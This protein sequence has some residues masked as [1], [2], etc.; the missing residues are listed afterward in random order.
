MAE[1]ATHERFRVQVLGRFRAPAACRVCGGAQFVETD[2]ACPGCNGTG[3][4]PG[5][6]IDYAKVGF[7]QGPD[8]G[9]FREVPARAL[10][11]FSAES[12]ISRPSEALGHE[13]RPIPLEKAEGGADR[14]A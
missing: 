6:L 8:R 2:G 7:L 1:Y 10:T 4:E 5:G 9:R 3:L 14:P 11:D 13:T 12:G